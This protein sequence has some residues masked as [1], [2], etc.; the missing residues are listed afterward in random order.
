MRDL[1]KIK[2]Q[3]KALLSK[4][5]ANGCTEAEMFAALAKAQAMMDAYQITDDDIRE[6]KEDVASLYT[7]ARNR[8]PTSDQMV[9]VAR[10]CGILQCAIYRSRGS[11]ALSII[12]TK[13]DQEQALWLF[14]VLADFVFEELY[15]H[16][17][18]SQPPPSEKKTVMRVF[19]ES[20][21]GRISQRL[22][23]LIKQSEAQRTSNGRELIVVK[24]AAITAYMKE[25]NIRIRTVCSGGG[26]PNEAAAAAGRAAGNRA[27][28]G[29]PI[30]GDA[31]V[32]RLS[33]V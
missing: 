7:E 32:L 26:N 16:L 18:V 19:V 6:A 33:K 2:A 24:N 13:S 14:D 29:R 20:C 4:T 11:R 25:H 9:F 21:C 3:I 28:F 17:I 12:G 10:H 5:T 23:D 22:E 1:E 31:G 30:S 8:R 15:K 27:N